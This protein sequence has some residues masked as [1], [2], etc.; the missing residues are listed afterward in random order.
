MPMLCNGK[1]LITQQ[2]LTN[3]H[4]CFVTLQRTK[5]L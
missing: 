5:I 2:V 4:K 3:N 1:H